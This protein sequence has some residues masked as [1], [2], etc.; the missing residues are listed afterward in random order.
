MQQRLPGVA[1]HLI[2]G[3]G[4]AV[5][6]PSEEPTGVHEPG[7]ERMRQVGCG[8]AWAY[9]LRALKLHALPATLGESRKPLAGGMRCKKY[10]MKQ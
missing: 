4:R 5:H 2:I 6:R 1:A 3:F 9:R 10:S 8:L 7:I